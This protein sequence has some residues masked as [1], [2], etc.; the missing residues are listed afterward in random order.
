VEPFRRS[1]AEL[2]EW[3]R[4]GRLAVCQGLGGDAAGAGAF[5]GVGQLSV[6]WG[7]FENFVSLY[8]HDFPLSDYR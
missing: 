6:P 8:V 2:V 5:L 7:Q 1:E 4:A 3:V